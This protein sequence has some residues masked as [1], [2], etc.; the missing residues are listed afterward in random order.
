MRHVRL[1]K[2]SIPGMTIVQCS[3]SAPEIVARLEKTLQSRGI[4][5]FARID[6][7]AN[8]AA[9][10]LILRPT[11]LLVFGDPRS[12]THLMQVAQTAGFDLPLRA[13][14]WTDAQ[15]ETWLGYTDV[16]SLAAKHAIAVDDATVAAIDTVLARIAAEVTS[17]QQLV[18]G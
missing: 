6:H 15:D 14:V 3:A 16:A 10:G 8:A 4:T 5:V 11:T 13:L 1:M 7:A 18:I 2:P 12:G 17:R 9:V